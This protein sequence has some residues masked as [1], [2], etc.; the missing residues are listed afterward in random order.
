MTSIRVLSDIKGHDSVLQQLIAI[1]LCIMLNYTSYKNPG[2]WLVNSRCI[3]RV[4]SYLGLISF[5]FTTVGVF[6]WGFNIF[7]L[8]AVVFAITYFTFLPSRASNRQIHSEYFLFTFIRMVTWL[9]KFETRKYSDVNVFPFFTLACFKPPNSSG[10]PIKKNNK[11]QIPQK[12]Y[13]KLKCSLKKPNK[14][15]IFLK[16]TD[17]RSYNIYLASVLN[18]I[19]CN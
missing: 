14:N 9:I 18:N 7:F 10:I 4:F 19:R 2:F 17:K 11:I 8:C 5:I 1:S 15:R 13:N 16:T 3:F 6:A 12:V